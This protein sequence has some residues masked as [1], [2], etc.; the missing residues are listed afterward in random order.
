MNAAHSMAADFHPSALT[1]I[2]QPDITIAIWQ[3]HLSST[4]TQYAKHLMRVSPDWQT[5]FIQ[6]PQKVAQQL[7]GELPLSSSRDAFIEDI[8]QVVDIFS[9]LFELDY[10]GLRMAVLSTA[11]CPKF[12][13][14]RIPCRLICTYAGGGTEWYS[15]EQVERLGNG[16][17]NPRSDQSFKSL[18]LGDVALLKGEAWEG[19][20]GR[21]LVHRSPAVAE[22]TSRLVLTLDF[23]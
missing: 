19:N 14:D 11:M 7:E 6:Q 1:E 13:I 5:R 22:N 17:I 23:V 10:I 4:I 21:G 18:R 12:H 9:C 8:V 2:Y 3:R 16:A 20:E 15:P